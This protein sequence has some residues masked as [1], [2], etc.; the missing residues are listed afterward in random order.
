MLRKNL[1]S[2]FYGA[3]LI[4]KLQLIWVIYW[5]NTLVYYSHLLYNIISE[6]YDIKKKLENF[7]LDNKPYYFRMKEKFYFKLIKEFVI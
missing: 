2:Q 7:I 6:I 4:T 5:G 3:S 1:F